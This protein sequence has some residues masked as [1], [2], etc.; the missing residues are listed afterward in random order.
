MINRSGRNDFSKSVNSLAAHTEPHCTLWLINGSHRS[1]REWIAEGV[2]SGSDGAKEA[3][4]S[5]TSV[6]LY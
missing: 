1:S 3:I 5:L 6:N 4:V 2:D